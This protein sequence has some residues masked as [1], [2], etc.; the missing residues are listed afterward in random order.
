MPVSFIADRGIRTST[1]AGNAVVSLTTGASIFAAPNTYLIA[2][3]GVDN[4]GTN[5]ALPGLAVTDTAGNTWTVGTGAL[6]DPG[7]AS[8]GIAAYLCYCKVVNAYT[9]SSTVTFTWTTGSPLSAIVIEEWRGIDS[10]TPVWTAQVI[11][12]GA[13]TAVA[14]AITPT[15]GNALLYAMTAI[16]GQSADWGTLDSDGLLQV[17]TGL[18]K[19]QANTG[20][21]A[22]SVS[23]YGGYKV[24][25]TT[26]TFAQ[27]WNNTLGASRSWAAVAI[28]FHAGV[29]DITPTRVITASTVPA[30]TLASDQAIAAAVVPTVTTVPAPTL[31]VDV[32]VTPAVV[33]TAVSVPAS[34]LKADTSVIPTSIATVASVLA[35][36]LVITGGST[37][38]PAAVATVVGIPAPTLKSDTKVTA[39]AV[40]T[41]TAVPAP[42]LATAQGVSP[43]V[44]PTV[45]TVP[46]PSLSAAAKVVATAVA[47][48][49]AIPAPT[50]TTPPA[51][52]E[53]TQPLTTKTKS[54]RLDAQPRRH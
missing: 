17:W 31:R 3:V 11:A 8:A 39:T 6:N 47:T 53:L 10:V 1:S 28:F 2:R 12:N 37:A 48:S 26:S 34:T 36:T 22:T 51:A 41:V 13:S 40:T 42:T 32:N 38:T 16:Q 50:I 45:A 54:T 30:V 19:D 5:G 18:T 29:V 20:T 23:V 21:T 49:A 46:A 43:S 14:V 35:P 44:V 15:N 25:P 52:P 9:N 4:S 7:V 24:I 33:V 27:T